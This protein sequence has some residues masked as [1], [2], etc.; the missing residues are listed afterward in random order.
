MNRIKKRFIKYLDPVLIFLFLFIIVSILF[1]YNLSSIN[2]KI[3][4]F[5]HYLNTIS[6][7]RILHNE[8]ESFFD[9][10]ATFI[11]Y[12]KTIQKTNEIYSLI[13]EFNNEKFYKRFG[14]ELRP[15]IELLDEKWNQKHEYLERFKSDNSAIVGSLNYIIELSKRIRIT[16]NNSNDILLFDNSLINLIMLFVNNIEIE[17][18]VIDENLKN[19]SSLSIKYDN[20]DFI[21]FNKKINSTVEKLT[22]LNT[23]KQEYVSIDMKSVLDSIEST[24]SEKYNANIRYQQIIAL[25]LFLTSLP[26]LLTLILIYVK[27]LKTKKELIA[28]K[29][30][31]ENS[32]NLIVITDKNRKIIYVN[33]SFEKVTGYKREETLGKDPSILKS[34]KLSN[35]FYQKMNETLNKGE[36]WTGEFI[37]VNKY[38]ELY[39]ETAS[40][41]PIITDNEIIG[42]LAIKLNITDYIKEQEKVEF[43]AYHDNLTLLPNRRSLERKLNE[44]IAK[45]T[46]RD[47]FAVL[48]LDLDGF[49]IINDTLGHDIGDLLLKEIAKKFHESLRINDY[50]FRLGGDEFAIIIEYSND[51]EIIE[52][53][54]KKIID[55]INK[56]INIRNNSLHVG[57]SIGIAKFPQDAVTSTN[58]LK[59][60]DIAMYK[61]KQNGRNRFE[62]YTKDLSDNVHSKLYIE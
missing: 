1:I 26:L 60:S 42:Y 62:F 22:K 56:N 51:I 32:D 25:I 55:N 21:F 17:E 41:T 57:C 24:L 46:R 50:V 11:N 58:L 4:N 47:K 12:D 38:D 8:F 19:L 35:E 9:N 7:I 39:Y 16:L 13:D 3:K 23:I 6:N 20:F 49:K 10:K 40:I 36:K 45:A 59:Y 44:L 43:L 37:N 31:V 28:F 34:G 27:S 33:E 14:N 54:A 29:Y 52:V 48:F 30:A 61:A 18:D 5:N 15:N 53:I 2:N